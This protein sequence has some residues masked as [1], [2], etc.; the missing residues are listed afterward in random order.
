MALRRS[1]TRPDSFVLAADDFGMTRGVSRAIL[2]LAGAGRL[3]ATGAMTNMPAWRQDWPGLRELDAVI[4]QGVHLNLTLGRPLGPMPRLAPGGTLP[5]FGD[6]ARRALTGAVPR[7]EIE[8]EFERQIRAFAEALGRL[9]DYLDGHQHVH[10]L[11]GVRAALGA[12]V[13]RLWAGQPKPWVRD[14]WDTPGRILARGVAPLKAGVIATLS[15]G[16]SGSLARRGIASNRG[17]SGVSSFDPARDFGEDFR[18]FLLAPGPAHLVMCH[19][20]LDDDPD[21]GGLDPVQTRGQE[22]AYLSGPRFPEHL[23]EARMSLASPQVLINVS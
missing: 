7:D 9:P 8:A 15:Q 23:D 21:L 20:G 16:L 2:A 11:P 17:F 3:S 18:R 10:A 1:E 5:R 12:V 4:A 14:P 13:E 19:P 22:F 6:L